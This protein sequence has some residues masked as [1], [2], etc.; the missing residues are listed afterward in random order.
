MSDRFDKQMPWHAMVEIR[1]LEELEGVR[2]LAWRARA[3]EEA[4]RAD[5]ELHEEMEK[6]RKEKYGDGSVTMGEDPAMLA[7]VV[8]GEMVEFEIV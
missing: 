2:L 3:K 6:E 5:L 7:M 1:G 8:E 4:E